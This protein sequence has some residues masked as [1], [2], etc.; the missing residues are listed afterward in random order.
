[1]FVT[2]IDGAAGADAKAPA[3][4]IGDI[5]RLETGDVGESLRG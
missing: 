5:S 4:Q 1:M 3:R 2:S